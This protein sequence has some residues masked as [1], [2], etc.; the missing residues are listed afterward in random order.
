MR[1]GTAWRGTVRFLEEN[2]RA[3][4]ARSP[5]HRH[6][7]D[8]VLDPEDRAGGPTRGGARV[9]LDAASVVEAVGVEQDFLFGIDDRLEQ[10]GPLGDSQ[11]HPARLAV[12][13]GAI[14]L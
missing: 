4:G 13:G 1:P 14:T 9:C 10:S 12:P 7:V 3:R 5:G 11:A 6:E 8:Q 2:R